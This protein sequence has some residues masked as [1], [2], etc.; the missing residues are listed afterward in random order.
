MKKIATS[1]LVLSLLAGV[2]VP[3]E[4]GLPDRPQHEGKV[5]LFRNLHANSKL[6]DDIENAG[7]ELLPS[8]AI[9][10]VHPHG[11]DFRAITDHHKAEGG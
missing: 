7:D 6:S 4:P 9:P 1:F 8:K 10:Y 3:A 5:V 2:L 11:L